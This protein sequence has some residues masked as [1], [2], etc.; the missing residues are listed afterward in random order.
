[1][2]ANALFEIILVISLVYYE[3]IIVDI[4]LK[5][6]LHVIVPRSEFI[7]ETHLNF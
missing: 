5:R 7:D 4:L 1:M 3:I 6:I 2:N